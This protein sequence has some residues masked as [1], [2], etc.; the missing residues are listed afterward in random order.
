MTLSRLVSL[1]V[2][3]ATSTS[4]L[5]RAGTGGRLVVRV[6][7]GEQDLFAVREEEDD[8]LPGVRCLPDGA[9]CKVGVRRDQ[10]RRARIW[11]IDWR[12]VF[13]HLRPLIENLLRAGEL[14][15]L[16]LSHPAIISS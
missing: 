13:G 14:R 12:P 3:P 8:R 6:A 10:R 4:R 15:S 7:R 1:I 9:H 16:H 2:R 5:V 11:P